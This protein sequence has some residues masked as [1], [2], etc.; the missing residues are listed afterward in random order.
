MLHKVDLLHLMCRSRVQR[1]SPQLNN[2]LANLTDSH[3][4]YPLSLRAASSKSTMYKHTVGS[5]SNSAFLTVLWKTYPYN[6]L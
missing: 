1:G 5:H 6:H 3:P 4:G 2:M